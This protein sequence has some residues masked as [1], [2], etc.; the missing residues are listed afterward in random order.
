MWSGLSEGCEPWISDYAGGPSYT[1]WALHRAGGGRSAKPMAPA[2]ARGMS[3][4]SGARSD[5][6]SAWAAVD[7]GFTAS[8]FCSHAEESCHKTAYST[9]SA[10]AT[11]CARVTYRQRSP[12]PGLRAPAALCTPL[13]ATCRRASA[14]SAPQQAHQC[15]ARFGT[16]LRIPK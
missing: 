14:V 1:I 10:P 13:A 12:R 5:A 2:P 9:S 4:E 3:F 16:H 6:E 7:A 11:A 15:L 8:V